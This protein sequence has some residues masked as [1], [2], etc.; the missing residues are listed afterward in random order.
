MAEVDP[1]RKPF[2]HNW[3]QHV[4]I[5]VK[6]VTVTI[7]VGLVV[8]I[9][10]DYFDSKSVRNAFESQMVDIMTEKGM[11][12]RQKFIHHIAEVT[13]T[14]NLLVS[15]NSL[16]SYM[17]DQPWNK[18]DTIK[19]NY[20][21]RV[22]N[23]FGRRENLLLFTIPNY[24]ILLDT[25]GNVRE[26]FRLIPEK[27]PDFLI[28][29]DQI[30]L[31]LSL[32]EP[33]TTGLNANFP[34]I[35]T[36]IK[37]VGS[38]GED[39]GYVMLATPIDEDFLRASLPSTAKEFL[40][41]LYR[42]NPPKIAVSSDDTLVSAGTDLHR[43]KERYLTAE[44]PAFDYG[45]SEVNY[46]FVI[47]IAKEKLE[48]QTMA[49]VEKARV[50]RS[51]MALLF[52][53]AFAVIMIRI[54]NRIAKLDRYVAE[55]SQSK[56][57]AIPWEHKKGDQLTQLRIRFQRLMEE[58]T[59]SYE[60]IRK[61]KYA[62]ESANR[63][64][65]TFLANMSHELR[66]PLNAI[67]GFSELMTRDT[68]ATPSQ[69]ENLRIIN[70]SGEHLLG[71]ISDVLDLSKIEAGRIEITMEAFDLFRFMND[72]HEMILI[73][74][75]KKNIS[76]DLEFAQNVERF[77]KT[78]VNKLRQILINLLGNAI[79]F[80]EE[81]GVTLRV[82][83]INSGENNIQCHL[84]VVVEDTGDGISA[85]QVKTIFTPFVQA[86]HARDD[87]VGTGLGLSIS[88]NFAEKLG[89]KISV[90]SELGKG[91][92]FILDIPVELVSQDNLVIEET[93]KKQITK[94]AS[95]QPEYRIS[96]AEDYP[97]NRVLLRDLLTHVGFTVKDVENGEDC[98][99]LFK[100]WNPHF[101]WMDLG[102][103]IV[104]GL[105]A[106]RQIRDL[107][108]GD[109]VKIVALTASSVF[110][111]QRSNVIA[112]GCD[113]ML[114]KPYKSQQILE[115][116]AKHLGVKFE[117]G[118]EVAISDGGNK[119]QPEL[120]AQTILNLP[121]ELREDLYKGAIS[122]NI[123]RSLQAISQI[124]E[125]DLELGNSLKKMVDNM[126]FEALLELLEEVDEKQS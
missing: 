80:T 100:T 28:K 12:Y 37:V 53:S 89:G 26:V 124:G 34:H 122:L 75:K 123:E 70:K 125:L 126:E 73:Q 3:L 98:I 83:T 105:E 50:R 109:E 61:E 54:T 25:W 76:F 99:S 59:A 77:V 60:I 32:N 68:E 17:K 106:T 35:I 91:S 51:V 14:A 118:E 46:Q 52:I 38:K 107:P 33:Y 111:D 1:D 58:I 4:S 117:Y 31:R 11:D 72:I 9:A 94:L 69:L 92:V 64:K 6:M 93:Q 49:V 87:I 95:N 18:E 114:Y 47:M 81:G 88:S 2:L 27:L 85:E 108:G 86:D 97:H 67:L 45:S 39:L 121:S 13:Q 23:W 112:Q 79:K 19:I 43:V 116:M 63:A 65:S 16:G 96:I 42:Q 57:K 66:T 101:I 71:M 22:P 74:A 78:D 41:G 102:M 120:Q 40:I 15:Q 90:E 104:D 10:V 113:D 20:H 30:F 29:P 48:P 36:T 5:T 7:V 119:Q 84:Q 55:F 56:L 110:N 44:Q 62:A 8:W 82:K 21:D 115:A 24:T 103:P